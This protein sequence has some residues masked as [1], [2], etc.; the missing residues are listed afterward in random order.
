MDE[1]VVVN[2]KDDPVGIGQVLLVHDEADAFQ[3][4]IAVK[5]REGIKKGGDESGQCEEGIEQGKD[6]VGIEQIEE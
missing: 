6:R 3:R 5:V 2:S 1:V 4:G